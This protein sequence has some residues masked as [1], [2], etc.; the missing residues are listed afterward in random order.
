MGTAE[1]W[2]GLWKQMG[3]EDDLEVG[4]LGEGHLAVQMTMPFLGA[5]SFSGERTRY[6]LKQ[7]WLH[8]KGEGRTDEQ[9]IVKCLPVRV[10]AQVDRQGG[11]PGLRGRILALGIRRHSCHTLYHD[12][13]EGPKIKGWQNVER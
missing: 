11:P 4:G 7:G 13:D 10:V 6:L 3:G 1:R 2:D 5:L 9:N 12:D 8:G